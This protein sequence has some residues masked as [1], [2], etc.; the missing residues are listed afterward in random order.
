MPDLALKGKQLEALKY[1]YAGSGVFVGF[2]KL[3]RDGDLLSNS[4]LL[5]G[6]QAW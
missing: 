1:L 3:W 5:V 6:C 4:T 2:N